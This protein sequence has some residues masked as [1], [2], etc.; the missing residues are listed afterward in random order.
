LTVK[1]ISSAVRKRDVRRKRTLIQKKMA[2]Q[3]LFL[4]GVPQVD[5]GDI[6]AS[7]EIGHYIGEG[8]QF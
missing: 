2:Q 5:F 4:S 8:P 1:K 3:N 6:S 7:V